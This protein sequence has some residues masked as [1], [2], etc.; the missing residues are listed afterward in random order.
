MT[1]GPIAVTNPGDE[2]NTE[3]DAVSLP[4]IASDLSN[5]ALTYSATGLP[6]GLSINSTTG[7]ISGTVAAGA[8]ED[9]P[10]D[11]VVTT[12]DGTTE[13]RRPA[14][15]FGVARDLSDGAARFE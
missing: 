6:G 9:G 3:G 8:E 11:V 12:T 15:R 5:S 1:V 10:F 7:V 13:R 4:I 14:V 2:N